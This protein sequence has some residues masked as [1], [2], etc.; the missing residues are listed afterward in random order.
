MLQSDFVKTLGV[1]RPVIVGLAVGVVVF[2]G[3]A[4]RRRAAELGVDNDDY[5]GR[6]PTEA[7]VQAAE[8]SIRVKTA[9]SIRRAKATLVRSAFVFLCLLA[10]M[11]P[12]MAGMPMNSFFRPWGQLLLIACSLALPS[13]VSPFPV[14]SQCA[15]TSG[16]WRNGWPV[17]MN[18]SSRSQIERLGA[19][20]RVRKM[21]ETACSCARLLSGVFHGLS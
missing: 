16:V 12:F 9:E 6:A 8:E 2:V 4:R 20:G 10:L 3:V 14:S 21:R 19:A 7:E 5:S 11:V 15:R 1:S 17:S 18:L 13:R